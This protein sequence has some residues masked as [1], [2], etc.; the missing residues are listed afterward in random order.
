MNARRRLLAAAS[1]TGALLALTAC[2]KPAPIVTV[3]NEGRSVYSEANVWCFEGQSGDECAERAEGATELE[4][5]RGTFGIDVAE[6]VAEGAWV[7]T[8]TPEGEPE[9]QLLPPEVHRDTHYFSFDFPGISRGT[10]LLLTVRA[11]DEDGEGSRG[12][13]Q[14]RLRPR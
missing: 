9:R 14:F 8:L 12:L 6:E 2:E 4:V 5:Q 13:W 10:S 1:A 3:V 11:L 7:A